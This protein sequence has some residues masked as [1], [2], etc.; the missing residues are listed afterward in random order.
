[1]L[2]DGARLLTLAGPGGSG[3]TRLAIEAA[4]T[5]VPRFRSGVF[6]VGLA[7]LRDPSLVLDSISRTLGASDGLA[8][9]VGEREMLLLLDNLEQVA[10]SAPEL[11]TLVEACP[12][13]RLLVTSREFLRVRGEVGYPVPP[14]AAPEAA[15]LFCERSGLEPGP[16][17]EKLCA[18]T[19][20]PWSGWR[21]RPRS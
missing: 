17:I 12:H 3:K 10:D 9:H 8:E 19:S 2:G 14:L 18:R 7:T 21:P 11:A 20:A 4:A 15:E 1:M 6:W 5:L 13:L 16:V